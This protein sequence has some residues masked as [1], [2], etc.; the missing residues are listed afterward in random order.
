VNR[1]HPSLPQL[2]PHVEQDIAIIGAIALIYMV[3]F[4]ILITCRYSLEVRLMGRYAVPQGRILKGWTVRLVPSPEQ[5][6]RF[7]RD[8]GARRFVY[9][10]AVAAIRQALSSGEAREP[11][12]KDGG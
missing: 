4:S 10:W 9:N 7:K 11:S 8:D 5:I 1:S 2:Y 6:A 12:G 3:M